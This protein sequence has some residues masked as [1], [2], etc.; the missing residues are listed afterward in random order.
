MTTALTLV[1]E[2]ELD[3]T[4]LHLKGRNF[5]PDDVQWW[6]NV[7]KV[8]Y[9]DEVE[10]GARFGLGKRYSNGRKLNFTTG[11][12]IPYFD[13]LGRPV[14][15]QGRP[16]ERV[17]LNDWHQPGKYRSEFQ[18]SLHAYL[19]PLGNGTT[20]AEIL[21]DPEQ[22]IVITEGEFKAGQFT[23][24]FLP[25]IGVAGVDCFFIKGRAGV[26]PELAGVKW[27]GRV[28][29]IAFDA[30]LNKHIDQSTQRIVNFLLAH[31]AVVRVMHIEETPTYKKT[32]AERIE[33]FGKE[34]DLKMGLDD[35]LQAGGHGS[36][37]L[38]VSR[39]QEISGGNEYDNNPLLWRVATIQGNSQPLYMELNGDYAG[40]PRVKTGMSEVMED[41]M[42]MV[43][44][45]KKTKVIPAFAAWCKSKGRIKLNKVVLR[46]DLSPLSIVE[47]N[48]WNS[49]PGLRTA[50]RRN[51]RL[52]GYFLAYLKQF[53]TSPIEGAELSE[54]HYR[55]YL[56]WLAAIFQ[57]PGD[58]PYSS[59]TFCSPEEGIGKSAI[60]ELAAQIIGLGEGG[61]ACVAGPDEL[62]GPWTGFLQG[63]V[64]V[65]VNEPSSDHARVK[66]IMKAY[67]TNPQVA[68]NHK[69][70]AHLRVPN[71]LIF[72]FTTNERFAF[73]IKE[74]ARRDFVW[75][76]AQTMTDK[77]WVRHSSVF[78]KLAGGKGSRSDAFRAAVMWG[79]L[80]EIDLDNYNPYAPALNSKAKTRAAAAG[81][82]L[83]QLNREQL[84][85][86]V[87]D[88]LE[89]IEEAAAD[90][91]SKIFG[92]TPAIAWDS[93]AWTAFVG[94]SGGN[95]TAEQNDLAA[96][97][98]RS[99]WCVDRPQI[100]TGVGS[101][102]VRSWAV[103]RKLFSD[104][105]TKEKR[106]ALA[107][108]YG[109]L[110]EFIGTS[111]EGE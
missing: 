23:K 97:L 93:V 99:G 75:E 62:T 56:R 49:W 72:I 11:L 14:L 87:T 69:S 102:K 1:A 96:H 42:L 21:K 18:S 104:L 66:Q 6:K 65:V 76:P 54:D 57:R 55:A 34:A 24:H 79:L 9:C 109:D 70:G 85:E 46:P 106:A 64:L 77:K 48:N 63:V 29:H 4:E 105:K 5:S 28:V 111:E 94:T 107:A 60:A 26:V 39:A 83:T 86:R 58:R 47:G 12:L 61:G 51:D 17:R 32:I 108:G 37:L 89:R 16:Y 52:W 20:W 78:G 15:E 22:S 100:K 30:P 44:D 40:V 103:S 13:A 82:T 67:R 33:R 91:T 35:F 101:N 98:E 53:F 31:D 92:F 19:P 80:N 43:S 8:R 2:T 27:G 90:P 3:P 25:T 7:A 84:L 110:N 59:W 41:E 73:G 36:G 45:G 74:D 68:I 71:R 95:A 50:P 10:V 38:T 88:R 81:K